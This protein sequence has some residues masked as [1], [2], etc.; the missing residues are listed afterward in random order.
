MINK[1][2]DALLDLLNDDQVYTLTVANMS[3]TPTSP[4]TL[5]E[6]LPYHGDGAGSAAPLTRPPLHRSAHRRAGRHQR[7]QRRGRRCVRSH[8]GRLATVSQDQQRPP[9]G[10][11]GGLRH[12]R[13]PHRFRRDGVRPSPASGS[14]PPPRAEPA[15]RELHAAGQDPTDPFS[16]T[17]NAAGDV[18]TNRFTAFSQSFSNA[19]GLQ[20][21][22]SNRVTV[23]TIGFA[24]GNLVFAD[25]DG[26]GVYDPAVDALVP[27]G[28]TV[29][30]RSV[31]DGALRATTTTVD[32]LYR[33]EG[34][35]AA[36][37]SCRSPAAV[38]PGGLLRLDDHAGP[39]GCRRRGRQRRRVH[40]TIAGVGG[41]VVA[42]VHALSADVAV[43]PS[44]ATPARRASPRRPA[45]GQRQL[46]NLAIDL[47]LLPAPAIDIEV[48]GRATTAI[49]RR[50]G[51]G[52]WSVDGVPGSPT[53]EV[54]EIIVG[55]DAVANT[56]T[57]TGGTYL[58]DVVVNDSLVP[59]CERTSHVGGAHRD[60]AGATR[61][62]CVSTNVI[63]DI[64]P[65]TADVVGYPPGQDPDDPEAAPVTD[66]D[67]AN[68][69]VIRPKLELPKTIGTVEV[70]ADGSF[71][72]TYT[73]VV[74]N[75]ST[76]TWPYDLDDTPLFGDGITIATAAV[77]ADSAGTVEHVERSR[78][79]ENRRR[80]STRRFLVT[81]TGTIRGR[82][83][84]RRATANSPRPSPAPA[85]STRRR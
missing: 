17:A 39:A 55:N 3:G 22:A 69:V 83:P 77:E 26:N 19:Q 80:L 30:L 13:L 61:R 10:A 42:P 23:R 24:A 46:T 66:I 50:V 29:E 52:G 62:T 35:P 79:R 28:V 6:V 38:P 85:C 41:A 27:D 57:N 16:T 5:I 25:V 8:E 81:V 21:L 73:L 51:T 59:T 9:P 7:Q 63:A 2:V 53:S 72:V 31:A 49:R 67:T 74:G 15:A 68:V 70:A 44:T 18:Y 45:A 1:S 33:F 76:L 82:S 43:P 40:D 65:N 54:A 84:R 71:T 11:G 47:A 4:L 14:R 32:G 58:Y 60:G 78:R 12:R 75:L 20:L 36:T 34:C 56:V 48:C 64:R 37:T